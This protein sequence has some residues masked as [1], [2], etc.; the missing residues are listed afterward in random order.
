MRT[1]IAAVADVALVLASSWVVVL[2][3]RA[4][5]DRFIRRT[6]EREGSN[7]GYRR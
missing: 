4:W 6:H 2:L 5:V 1:F 3:L 7:G